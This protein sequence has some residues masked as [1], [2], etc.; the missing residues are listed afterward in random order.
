[1]VRGDTLGLTLRYIK[2]GSRGPGVGELDHG[3]SSERNQELV[4]LDLEYVS[5]LSKS[6]RCVCAELK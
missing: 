2:D 5:K 3:L 1:M 4:T 6:Q